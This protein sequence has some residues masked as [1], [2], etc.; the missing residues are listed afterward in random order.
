MT[1]STLQRDLD[2]V[3][4]SSQGV[5]YYSPHYEAYLGWK[6][7]AYPFTVVSICIFYVIH[8]SILPQHS[9]EKS[10]CLPIVGSGERL[11]LCSGLRSTTVL[12]PWRV[13]FPSDK[14]K[15]C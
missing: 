5:A 10:G 12:V 9:R 13:V 15:S 1:S 3:C 11:V 4:I 8:I 14:A 6:E 7:S 2:L